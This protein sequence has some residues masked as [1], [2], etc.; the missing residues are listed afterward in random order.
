MPHEG[1][2]SSTSCVLGAVNAGCNYDDDGA[3]FSRD[4]KGLRGAVDDDGTDGAMTDEGGDCEEEEVFH[5]SLSHEVL[6]HNEED[7]SDG[8]GN[9]N[10]SDGVG[11]LG[12]RKCIGEE[13]CTATLGRESHSEAIPN[14][15]GVDDGM[16]HIFVN[17]GVER[18]DNHSEWLGDDGSPRMEINEND[19]QIEVELTGNDKTIGDEDEHDEGLSPTV[20]EHPPLHDHLMPLLSTI[21]AMSTPP[22][23]RDRT[24]GSSGLCAHPLHRHSFSSTSASLF[25]FTP[26]KCAGCH[27]RLVRA[28]LFGGS[29]GPS[30]SP[31]NPSGTKQLQSGVTEKGKGEVVKCMACSV[32]AHRACAFDTQHVD[33]SEGLCKTNVA[34]VGEIA[35]KVADDIR[36][37]T[38]SSVHSN[39]PSVRSKDRSLAES[40]NGEEAKGLNDAKLHPTKEKF[41]AAIQAVFDG[42]KSPSEAGNELDAMA[43]TEPTP[44]PP[45]PPLVAF[46]RSSSS[47]TRAR[48]NGLAW[49]TPDSSSSTPTSKGGRRRPRAESLPSASEPLGASDVNRERS[50]T[51]DNTPCSPTLKQSFLTM[52]NSAISFGSSSSK[53]DPG[54]DDSNNSNSGE[55]LASPP[56]RPLSPPEEPGG[57]LWTPDGPPTHW[58]R[59]NPSSLRGL[60]PGEH[61]LPPRQDTSVENEKVDSWK[62]EERSF[63][64]PSSMDVSVCPVKD[65]KDRAS[66]VA[67]RKSDKDDERTALLDDKRVESNQ[68][69]ESNAKKSTISFHEA[70]EPNAEDVKESTSSVH[71]AQESFVSV[72][73]AL[74]ENIVAH[75][76][77]ERSTMASKERDGEGRDDIHAAEGGEDR[78]A[79][80]QIHA[81]INARG[82]GIEQEEKKESCPTE[83]SG[84]SAG[85]ELSSLSLPPLT[86]AA[87]AI[88]QPVD[89]MRS[90]EHS[91]T[92]S[93]PGMFGLNRLASWRTS[94]MAPDRKGS[95][96]ASGSLSPTS[97]SSSASSSL[98]GVSSC[99]AAA[100]GASEV[101][102]IHLKALLTEVDPKPPSPPPPEKP[103]ATEITTKTVEAVRSAQKSRQS[104]GIASVAGGI[105]GGVAG[106][107]I[108]GPAGAFI[109]A[110][111]GQSAGLLGIIL[112]G[113]VNVGIFVASIAAAS[114]TADRM[115]DPGKRM[116]TIGEEG[117]R[118]VVLVRP[119]VVVDPIWEEITA[120]ARRTC[121]TIAN[122]SKK[123][124]FSI[125]A[126]HKA[127][128]AELAK[129]ERYLRDSDIVETDESEI[130]TADKVLLLVSRSLNDKLS[131]PG[132]IHREL[133]KEHRDRAAQRDAGILDDR[134]TLAT[135]G[136]NASARDH[137]LKPERQRSFSRERRQDTHGVIKHVT[138][139]LLEIRP[140]FASSP[141]ITEMSATAVENLLFGELYDSVFD[142][143][144]D[145]TKELD[146]ALAQKIARFNIG[147]GSFDRAEGPVGK[148]EVPGP[149]LFG[150]VS[151]EAIEALVML[152]E[153]H[154]A[155]DKL[156]YC[157]QF[158]E[159][160]SVQFSNVPPPS[161]DGT[162]NDV[163]VGNAEDAAET[164]KANKQK[165]MGADTLLKMVCQHI[166]LAKV[167]NLNAEIAFLEE[168]ARDEHLLRG[169]EGYALVTMQASLHFLNAS[170]NF[171]RDIFGSSDHDDEREGAESLVL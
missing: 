110:K 170:S 122:A 125:I 145:E 60:V 30:S 103:T 149:G 37:Q 29:S 157:V 39:D 159:L 91:T 35:E 126:N 146:T 106:L 163:V 88:E 80:A 51:V 52:F 97:P 114:F 23:R 112:E 167:P 140:G 7:D 123:S 28:P 137:D 45:P 171:E 128:V 16:P 150:N 17:R 10:D 55:G 68:R 56:P 57:P 15:G 74:Q 111:L 5:D 4:G 136:R 66:S 161:D 129:R 34:L 61:P 130:N 67:E 102:S 155:V 153:A 42:T 165:A 162:S 166:I 49:M 63:S 86:A 62:V 119:N 27:G 44:P 20:E 65:D 139:T 85:T 104:L 124:T 132:H 84:L 72:S 152:P 143:I 36:S 38:N 164:G 169:K 31:A 14:E 47:S 160:I 2:A 142:E 19:E 113:S 21:R 109:G 77:R 148:D 108:A 96:S 154:S 18:D 32:Y 89:E 58:A 24:K 151:G 92:P 11:D 81:T 138:A 94:T 141:K 71:F 54:G 87:A 3:I 120:E 73:R 43:D 156:A 9:S 100:P 78:N 158:L 105:A 133:I 1:R 76:R 6:L 107:Y 93:Q 26:R 8:G 53:G 134:T 117:D 127:K 121:P 131:L 22:P 40:L 90:D 116:L 168:F 13:N 12:D 48:K 135:E 59:S 79:T 75:F 99:G 98:H 69:D 50:N 41:S 118:K 25:F 46:S 147:N 95:S 101:S 33:W 83:L 70:Q 144:V 115:Q 64:L 82:E